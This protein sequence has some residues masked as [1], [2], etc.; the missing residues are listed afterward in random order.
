M[1]VL[2]ILPQAESYYYQNKINYLIIDGQ[3]EVIDSLRSIINHLEIRDSI[4]VEELILKDKQIELAKPKW[5]QQPS[6]IIIKVISALTI[7]ILLG[8]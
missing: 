8:S 5:W 7:G 3:K 2:K 6:V 1:N 4:R